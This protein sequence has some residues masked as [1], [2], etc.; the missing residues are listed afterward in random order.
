MPPLPPSNTHTVAVVQPEIPPPSTSNNRQRFNERLQKYH[1]SARFDM[2]QDGPQHVQRW[3]C[4]CYIRN[5]FVGC[6]EWYS[7][8][9]AAKEEAAGHALEWMDKYG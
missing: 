3:R 6:S 7:N 2:K 1:W 5:T 8:K 4:F 9:D